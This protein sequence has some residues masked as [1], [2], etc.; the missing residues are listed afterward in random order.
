MNELAGAVKTQL[1]EFTRWWDT[2]GEWVEPA[3]QRR[4]EESGVQLLIPDDPARPLLYSKRQQGHIY[5]SL[6]YPFG[7]PTVL[8]EIGAYRAIGQLGILTPKLVYADVRRHQRQWRALLITEALQ[9]FVNLEDWY[10]EQKP[11]ALN[12]AMLSQL[13]TMLAR[14]H[15]ARWQHG[16]C[17]P[18]HIFIRAVDN[19]TN[20]PS[21]EAA[22][23]D[24]EK[25]RHRLRAHTASQRDMSQLARHRG[26]MPEIDMQFLLD[27]YQAA[28]QNPHGIP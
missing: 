4:G 5:R 19:H 20:E 6:R 26:N 7:R 3:N 22:L 15:S 17:Y 25:S 9:G 27:A 14:L 24:L 11:A 28:L 2:Q 8:R 16:C 13:A 12:K 18:K 21:V 1:D 10:A 23:L